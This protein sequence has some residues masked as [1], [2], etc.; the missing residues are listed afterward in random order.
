V[1]ALQL[2][3]LPELRQDLALWQ[4]DDDPLLIWDSRG[5]AWTVGWAEEKRWRA[6]RPG[7]DRQV[8]P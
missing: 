6:R 1:T 7:H 8:A 5:R 4:E 2:E 3:A